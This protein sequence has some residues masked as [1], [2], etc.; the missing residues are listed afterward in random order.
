MGIRQ[1]LGEFWSNFGGTASPD[2]SSA[3][4]NGIDSDPLDALNS[5]VVNPA[6]GLPMIGGIGGL[7][8]AGNPFGSDSSTTDLFDHDDMSSS[9]HWD[10]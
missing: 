8:L 6:S 2:D 9:I 5:A 10:D 1:W 7:D 4:S 3:S